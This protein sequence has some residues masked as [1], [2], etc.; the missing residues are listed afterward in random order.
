[1]TLKTIDHGSSWNQTYGSKMKQIDDWINNGYVNTVVVD[2]LIDKNKIFLVDPDI[3]LQISTN[4]GKSW[5]VVSSDKY[6]AGA[7]SII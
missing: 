5:K 2:V 4:S 1:M 7:T 6:P 3:G